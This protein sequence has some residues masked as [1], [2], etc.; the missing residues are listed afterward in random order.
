MY[1]Q[2][3]EHD[4]LP[5][6]IITDYFLP[7]MTGTEFVKDLKGMD[8]YKHIP[9]IVLTTTKSEKEL[10]KYREMGALDYL[11]KPITYNDYVRVAAD[12]KSRVGI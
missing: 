10:E 11:V 7:G 2:E 6:L 12:M 9:V 3:R 4:C 5:K 8:K 1:L